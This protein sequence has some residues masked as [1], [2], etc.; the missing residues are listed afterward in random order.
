MIN[1]LRLWFEI[2]STSRCTGREI[3]G[4]LVVQVGDVDTGSVCKCDCDW[5]LCLVL[6]RKIERRRLRLSCVDWCW[7]MY[8]YRVIFPKM[9][10]TAPT[11]WR[12]PTT[13]VP[14]GLWTWLTERGERKKGLTGNWTQDLSQILYPCMNILRKNHTARPSG[15]INWMFGFI[16]CYRREQLSGEASPRWCS[17]CRRSNFRPHA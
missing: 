8:E 15:H 14:A 2:H 17:R 4:I 3:N 16:Y 6:V 9:V 12:S 11:A 7:Y 5:R 13:W 10:D 1:T